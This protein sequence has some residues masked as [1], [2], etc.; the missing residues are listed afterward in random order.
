MPLLMIN[1][2][3]HTHPQL[4]YSE[5]WIST[6]KVW[7][8]QVLGFKACQTRLG[9]PF[10]PKDISLSILFSGFL[11]YFVLIFTST[12]PRAWLTIKTKAKKEPNDEL[13][14]FRMIDFLEEPT[15]PHNCYFCASV[16]REKCRE[17][18]EGELVHDVCT[19]FAESLDPYLGST[20][21]RATASQHKRAA[22]MQIAEC[23]VIEPA[24]NPQ[25]KKTGLAH[26]KTRQK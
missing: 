6:W 26:F 24:R 2:L 13:I 23:D 21:T 4:M 19:L 7:Q 17:N 8:G 10:P 22:G 20:R 16:W 11:L 12:Q 14:Y 5:K 25:T 9:R 15:H 18:I 1:H 3:K